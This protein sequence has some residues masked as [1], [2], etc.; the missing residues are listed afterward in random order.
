MKKFIYLC[1]CALLVSGLIAEELKVKSDSFYADQKKGFSVFTGHVNIIKGSDELNAS[2]VTIYT[3]K[4]N[5][6]TKFVSEGKSSF[7]IK[8]EDGSK[9]K[10]KAHKVVYLPNKKEYQFYKDVHL[11]QLNNKK[12]IIGEEVILNTIDGKAIA[13]GAQNEPVIMIFN[14]EEKKEK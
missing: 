6:P 14:I 4:N 11:K 2:K 1:S 12:E 9:Y 8:T 13:K 3:D 7:K 10:G 5:Q